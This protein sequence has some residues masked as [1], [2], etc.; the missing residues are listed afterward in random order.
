MKECPYDPGG[1]FVVKGV[2]KVCGVFSQICM[3]NLVLP[4]RVNSWVEFLLSSRALL[5]L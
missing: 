1:Y 2:E 5:L 3:Y 4:E